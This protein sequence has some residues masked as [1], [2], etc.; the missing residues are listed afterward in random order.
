VLQC[1]CDLELAA[2]IGQQLLDDNNELQMRNEFL[3]TQ[4]HT[5]N[6]H[7]VALKADLQRK[8]QL[9]HDVVDS[10][11][12][13]SARTPV[14]DKRTAHVSVL[15]TTIRELQQDNRALKAE[16]GTHLNSSHS[17]FVNQ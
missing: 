16:V 14:N 5:S 1:Q 6:E 3:E 11:D 12:V 17:P 8:L 9:L 15:E 10:D 13:D 2:R 7:I 4:L